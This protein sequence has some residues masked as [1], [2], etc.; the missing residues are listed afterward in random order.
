MKNQTF[1]HGRIIENRYKNIV[2]ARTENSCS[3]YFDYPF[4]MFRIIT[5]KTMQYIL[6]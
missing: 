4:L 1:I 6:V 2:Y 3:P 5:Y